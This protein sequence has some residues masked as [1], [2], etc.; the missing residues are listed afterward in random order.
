M[1]ERLI[2][3]SSLVKPCKVFAD[4]GCD[5]GYI[6][7]FVLENNLAE[8]VVA[9]D[10][11]APSLEKCKNRLARF[12]KK[13]AA[14]VADGL[15]GVK[16]K[17]EQVL[18]AGMGGK[19][20]LSILSDYP[21]ADRVILQPM[22]NAAE[23]R[24]YLLENDFFIERDFTFFSLSK[25]YD[26]IVGLKNRCDNEFLKTAEKAFCKNDYDDERLLFGIENI[27]ASGRFKSYLEK[28]FSE[29]SA[30]AAVAKDDEQRE[31]LNDYLEKIKR[32]I[33]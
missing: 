13:Y 12:E 20:I 21:F 14:Y 15:K 7:E 32:V 25:K 30:A 33:K 24:K 1:T 22:K 3:L 11:S 2:K 5:H 10:I 8:F 16:E 18:I 19:E 4:V 23:V 27:P 17:P 6:S 28:T 26:V 9:T 29:L 31:K